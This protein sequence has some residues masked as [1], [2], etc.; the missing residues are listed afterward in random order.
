M[1]RVA[2]AFPHK[3]YWFMM[4]A[5]YLSHAQN[6]MSI[7]AEPS[8]LSSLKYLHRKQ[9]LNN[10]ILIMLSDHGTWWRD[11]IEASEAA[12]LEQRL[13]I[14]YISLPQK[15]KRKYPLATRNLQQ[16]AKKLTTTFDVYEMMYD[17]LNLTQVSDKRILERAQESSITAR[18]NVSLFLPID[19][20]RTCAEA[21]ITLINCACIS[22]ESASVSEPSVIRAANFVL[23]TINEKIREYP[24]C[25]QLKLENVTEVFLTGLRRGSA[26]G[27]G[28]FG[29]NIDAISESHGE[30]FEIGISTKPGGGKYYAA[31]VF[32]GFDGHL[33]LDGIARVSI[34][35]NDA[36]CMSDQD[37]KPFCYCK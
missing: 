23:E 25:R 14:L 29:L 21:G 27:N 4:M 36:D 12:F 35:G 19:P 13:P 7:Y 9:L 18:R 20:G 5:Q 17:L 32:N 3:P 31:V 2:K 30:Y 28:T 24:Q 16:N 1:E 6:I 15:F 33:T 11:D 34:Y 37:L 10:T 22:R 8:I 26:R